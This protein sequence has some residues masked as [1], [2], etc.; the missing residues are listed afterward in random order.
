MS[1]S[2]RRGFSLRIFLPDGSPDGL[3]V[4]EKTNWSGEGVVCPRPLLPQKKS[5]AEFSRTGVYLLIGPPAESGLPVVYIGEA[6]QIRAR[7]EQHASGKD[8]WTTAIFFTSKDDSLNKADVQY[9]ESKLIHLAATAKRCVLENGNAPDRCSLSE[10]DQATAD[11]FLDELLL[12]LPVLGLTVFEKPAAVSEQQQI[13]YLKAKDCE[14]RGYESSDGFVVL[15]GS[16]A[17]VGET[18]SVHSYIRALRKTLVDGGILDLQG[19]QYVVT[20]DYVFNS[21]STAAAVMAGR[22]ANGRREWKDGSGKELKVIQAEQLALDDA[23]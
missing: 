1:S 14:C 3:K 4:V 23:D 18:Q 10:A 11:G 7:L 17:R 6:E 22:S 19:G 5:R 9:L 2:Q 12:C 15:A 20:Q 16:R 8:F 21:P 13:L